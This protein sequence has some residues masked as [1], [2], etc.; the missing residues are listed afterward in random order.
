MSYLVSPEMAVVARK[1]K[2][3]ERA[4]ITAEYQRQM[5]NLQERVA[6]EK[7][8]QQQLEASKE[9]ARKDQELARKEIADRE[10]A[11]ERQIRAIRE[12]GEALAREYRE[13]S[14]ESSER[15]TAAEASRRRD[16]AEQHRTALQMLEATKRE[17]ESLES[18]SAQQ[19]SIL[20]QQTEVLK[21]IR[22]EVRSPITQ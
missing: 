21:D 9:Q 8:A 12:Q 13:S 6:R 16:L 2:E 19:N 4:A 22:T 18:R 1:K 20:Q 10:W 7:A 15:Q 14:R 11:A 5:E 17:V 3:A